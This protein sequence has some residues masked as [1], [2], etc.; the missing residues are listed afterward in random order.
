M[1]N[2][3]VI[4]KD[5]AARAGV[6]KTLHGD[7]ETPVYMPV[8]TQG[9]VKALTPDDLKTL[10]AQIILGNTYHLNLRPT[11]ELIKKMGGLH[12]FMRWDGPML[13]DSGGFQAFSLGAMIEHG[14]KK[15]QNSKGKSQ[16]YNSKFENRAEV[17][18]AVD[19]RV[20]NKVY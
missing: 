5:G 10:G 11:S 17:E 14:V 18:Q 9:T 19:I 13:T 1:S 12:E 2:F 15:I 3:K 7:V 8:G 20:G 16:N 6:L 4:A